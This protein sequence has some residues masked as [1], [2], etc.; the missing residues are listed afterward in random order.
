MTAREKAPEKAAEVAILG[1]GVFSPGYADLAAFQ[2]GEPQETH[3]KPDV[4]FVPPRQRRRAS[5]LSR[6]FAHAYSRALSEAAL[7]AESVASVFGSALGEA[8]TMVGLLDQMWTEGA[9][10]SPMRFT[11]SVHNTASGMLSIASQNRG[12][13]T[14]LGADFDTAAMALLEGIGLVLSTDSPV[15]V[16]CCDETPPPDLVKDRDGWALLAVGVAIGPAASAR[17]GT[18]R[19]GDMRIEPGS[20]TPPEIDA[21]ITHNPA[22]GLLDLALAARARASGRV[23]LDRGL[24]RGYSVDVTSAPA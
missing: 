4:S 14:S 12:F 18:A 5:L 1:V 24:G 7:E 23:A 21:A 6:A 13:T 11:T 16:C 19:L 3:E 15:I 8:E 10:L 9:A 17:E 22:A 2:A 20:W